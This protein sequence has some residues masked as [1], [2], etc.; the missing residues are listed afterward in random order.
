MTYIAGIR[1]G[2]HVFLVSDSAVTHSGL[3]P[4]DGLKQATTSFGEA[5]IFEPSRTVQEAALKIHRLGQIAVA[6][7]GDANQATRCIAGLKATL[8]RGVAPEQALAASVKPFAEMDDLAFQ[9]IAT[10][11]VEPTPLLMSFNMGGRRQLVPHFGDGVVQTGSPTDFQIELFRTVLKL[12]DERLPQDPDAFLVA[13]VAWLQSLGVREHL[14]E[15]GIGGAFYGLYADAHQ[16]QWMPDVVFGIHHRMSGPVLP[17]ILII[18][19]DVIIVRSGVDDAS[20]ALYSSTSSTV[21]I[22]DWH[23]RWGTFDEAVLG[24]STRF[25]VLIDSVDWRV[26][27]FE[28]AADQSSHYLRFEGPTRRSDGRIQPV[29]DLVPNVLA[30]LRLPVQPASSPAASRIMFAWSPS[31]GEPKMFQFVVE[32]VDRVGTTE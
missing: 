16:I 30:V 4:P 22:A 5:Q 9:L 28:L 14:L 8:D 26:A 24:S 18:R 17:V 10:I 21:T 2:Q 3:Q 13:A 32:A 27:M 11:A 31:D 6:V 25:V 29:V 12:L 15:N 7:A 19:D 1:R 20:R 23:A